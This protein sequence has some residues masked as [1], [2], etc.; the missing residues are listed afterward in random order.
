MI[1][2]KKREKNIESIINNIKPPIF[3][4]DKQNIV[5]Q[6][7][8]WNIEKIQIILKKSYDFETIIKSNGAIN[9]NM[10]IKKLLVDVCNVANS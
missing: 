7:K 5:D 6:S 2:L 4:K 8:V 1:S 3:W 9:K 10:L